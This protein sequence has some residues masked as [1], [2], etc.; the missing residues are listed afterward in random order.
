M[1]W[2]VWKDD[3]GWVRARFTGKLTTSGGSDSADEFL[4]VLGQDAAPVVFDISEMDGYESGAR[5]AWQQALWPHRRK[6]QSITLVGGNAITRMGGQILGL[7]LGVA[8]TSI[9]STDELD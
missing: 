2:K 3:A 6:I 7:A 9:K 8:V 1:E 5:S 4:A